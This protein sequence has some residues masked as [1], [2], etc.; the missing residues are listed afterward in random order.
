MTQVSSSSKITFFSKQDRALQVD[1][2]EV[3]D[4]GNHSGE[5]PVRLGPKLV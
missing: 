1:E 4:M 2:E 5:D 3:Y